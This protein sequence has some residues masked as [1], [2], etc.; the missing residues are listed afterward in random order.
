MLVHRLIDTFL[1]TAELV[2]SG[3]TPSAADQAVATA[4]VGFLGFP[5]P[6]IGSICASGAA[7]TLHTDS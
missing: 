1:N 5:W 2:C 7:T 6:S 3:A 4:D